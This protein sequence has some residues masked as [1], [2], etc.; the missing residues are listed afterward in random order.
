MHGRPRTRTLRSVAMLALLAIAGLSLAA[1]SGGSNQATR[2][3]SQTFTGSHRVNSGNL[4]LSITISPSGSSALKSPITLSLGGPFQSRGSGKLP[5][6]NFSLGLAT[7]GGNVSV[8]L[9]STGS[10][11]YVTFQGQS[12]PLPQATYQRLESSF[13]QLGASP[14]THRSSGVLARL[15]IHPEHWLVNPQVVGN[16][17]L[18]GTNTTHIRAGI[19]VAA[20]VGDLNTFLG[21]AA[22]V[23]ASASNLPSGISASE[24]QQIARAIRNT[25]IDVWTGASD[26]TLRRLDLRLTL[27]L[28]GQTAALLGSRA[29]LALTL[30]YAN[31]NQPQTI[32][33]PASVQ[34]YSEFQAKLKVLLADLQSGLAGGLSGGGGSSSGTSTGTTS[35]NSSYQNYTQCMQAAGGDVAKMQNCA[36]LLNGGG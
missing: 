24:R 7:G 20:L 18:G 31:L 34:P 6:S 33:A 5:R 22:S 15:G 9:L 30:Q 14:G 10:R 16:E 17:A 32:V 19:N 13:S 3:L 25:A 4:G 2:L 8:A 35:A 23:G 11:G 29:T 36:P 28:T 21:R 26:K 27:D 12:Y 1:C